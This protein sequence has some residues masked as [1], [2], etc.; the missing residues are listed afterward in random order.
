MPWWK[1]R[2]FSVGT[3][4]L[5]KFLVSATSLG[6][7]KFLWEKKCLLL[8]ALGIRYSRNG[9]N[10]KIQFQKEAFSW[11]FVLRFSALY[12]I[13]KIM[14]VSFMLSIK[15]RHIIFDLEYQTI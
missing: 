2:E 5:L 11:N 13:K 1:L 12:R 15:F 7:T 4:N 14:L 8:T 6:C 10:A 3:I 9:E